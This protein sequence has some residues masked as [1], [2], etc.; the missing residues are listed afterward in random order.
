MKVKAVIVPQVGDG[1][2]GDFCVIAPGMTY[3]KTLTP[4]EEVFLINEQERPK[5]VFGRAKVRS[6]AKG[7]M[8]QLCLLNHATHHLTKL[9]EAS[10]DR[11]FGMLVK[12]YGPDIAT[13]T[14]K[15]SIVHLT[16]IE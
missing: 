8:L 16:L 5:V 4:G 1:V 7:E 3:A 11:L 15:S 6:A 13:A 14:R 2:T 10:G 9:I 12:Q